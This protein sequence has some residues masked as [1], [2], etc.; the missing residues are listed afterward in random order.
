M[1]KRDVSLYL[2]DILIA[3][4]KISRYTQPFDNSTDF[5]HSELEWDATIRE[6]QLVGD[7]IN[8][9]IKEGIL[10]NSFRRIVDFRNQIVHGCFG[11]DSDIVWEVVNLKIPGLVK[12]IILIS[13]KE[14]ISLEL[15]IKCAIEDNH[16]NQELV[17][18][19]KR[20]QGIR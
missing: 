13:S 5:L 15:A 18:Y 4:N 11:I 12:E 19:L 3:A 1:S 10:N 14:N 17:A 6:L 8:V 7:A 9:L 16:Y 20:L 2:V